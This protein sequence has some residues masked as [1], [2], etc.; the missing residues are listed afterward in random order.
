MVPNTK[1][2]CVLGPNAHPCVLCPRSGSERSGIGRRAKGISGRVVS[3]R[4]CSPHVFSTEGTAVTFYG[5]YPAQR[6]TLAMAS[7]AYFLQQGSLLVA[8]S[9]LSVTRCVSHIP[10]RVARGTIF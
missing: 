4:T 10:F 8:L 3:E 2:R 7:V 5:N 9:Q 1:R 6:T